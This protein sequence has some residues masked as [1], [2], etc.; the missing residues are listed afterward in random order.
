MGTQG[1]PGGGSNSGTA[2]WVCGRCQ[3]PLAQAK[4]SVEYLGSSF[5]LELPRCP[6]CG[7][8]FVAETLALGKMLQAE[9]ALEDK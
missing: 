7:Y 3:V 4:V 6:G 2:G 8:V 5:P 9:Q 1:V